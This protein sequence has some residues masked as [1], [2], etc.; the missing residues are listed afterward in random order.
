[1]TAAR[2]TASL[3]PLVVVAL[4]LGTIAIAALGTWLLSR[5]YLRAR[6]ALAADPKLG[7][8][9]EQADLV[10]TITTGTGRLEA[11][12]GIQGD[13]FFAWGAHKVQWAI[14]TARITG[15]KRLMCDSGETPIDVICLVGTDGNLITGTL[16]WGANRYPGADQAMQ[17]LADELGCDY[18]IENYDDALPL[19]AK[20]YGRSLSL[21]RMSL[22]DWRTRQVTAFIVGPL[23]VAVAIVAATQ[24]SI[25]WAFTFGALGVLSCALAILSLRRWKSGPV[26]KKSGGK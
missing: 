7:L 6:H 26:I 16:S 1:M 23:F 8:S 2:T 3:P 24:N 20:R 22:L 17:T 18:T 4:V 9:P 10:V 19:F 11:K 5:K 12:Y 15:I 14:P 21:I 13:W 25:G